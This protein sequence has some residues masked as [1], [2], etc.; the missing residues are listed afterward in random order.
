MECLHHVFL[1]RREIWVHSVT[2]SPALDIVSAALY[3]LGVVLLILR[4]IRR[5]TWQDLLLLLSVPL[6]MLPSILS[7]AFPDENP[8][9]NRAGGAIVPV[10][11]IIAIALDGLMSGVE[12]RLHSKTG[13]A[14]GL[15]DWRSA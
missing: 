12:K 10:F 14:V 6:L 9:L 3:F 11:L 2:G 13:S 7:L 5:R 15:G 8:A 1:V 4:Y